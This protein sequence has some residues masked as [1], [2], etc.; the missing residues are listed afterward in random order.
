MEKNSEQ[1]I[2]PLNDIV[3]DESIYPR[4]SSW[5]VT[6][7]KYSEE[8]KAGAIFPPMCVAYLDGRYV[9]VDGKHRNDALILNKETHTNCEVLF[10]YTK[11]ELYLEAI[12]RNIS[13][14]MTLSS[15]DK[16]KVIKTLQDMKFDLEKISQIVQIP[17][18]SI[19]NFMAK[20]IT[21]SAIGEPQILKSSLRHL[22]GSGVPV[23]EEDQDLLSTR[24]ELTLVNQMIQIFSN[25]N[26]PRKDK[27]FLEGL[28][29]LYELMKEFLEGQK[30]L[31][32]TGN[33]YKGKKG[34]PKKDK[35]L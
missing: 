9:L 16:M 10:G 26:F 29:K 13:H 1:K 22:S 8:M 34:R 4:Q 24:S 30:L 11:E 12:R 17:F 6:S 27:V 18:E 5:W 7:Y 33:K 35:K 21:M 3:F 19:S 25:K 28:L 23:S 14:G 2:L 31:T 15:F 32:G 20:R